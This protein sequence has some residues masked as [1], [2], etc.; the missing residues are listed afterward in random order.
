[1]E[2]PHTYVHETS[3]SVVHHEDYLNHRD[4]QALC[5]VAFENPA[6]LDPT[7]PPAE[8]CPNCEARLPE[9][10]LTFWREKAEAATAELDQLRIKY[11]ELAETAQVSGDLSGE[12]HESRRQGHAEP[13]TGA[14]AEQSEATPARLLDQAREE[15]V[16]LCRGFDETVPYWRVK[17]SMDAF[18]DKLGSEERVLLAEEIGAEGS[19]I[20]WCMKEIEGLGWQVSNSPVHADAD[21]MMDAWTEDYYQTP[22]KTKRRLGWHRS[23]D[24]S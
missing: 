10:H 17:N 4:D 15:L 12:T 3:S 20:R 6:Q 24:A 8:V 13:E 5:G 11:R 21:S 18:S 14:T 19:L 23:H 16:K 22:K 2:P 9:Y 1:M 7:I